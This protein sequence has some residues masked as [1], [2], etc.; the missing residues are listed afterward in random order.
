MI[1]PAHPR[2]TTPG[3]AHHAGQRV[4]AW[5]DV[6][7]AEKDEAK[8]LGARWDPAAKR[9]HDPRPGRA[10]QPRPELARWVA[11]VAVPDLLPG[12]DR[13]FGSGLFVDLI[14]E[15]CW[16]T[17]VRSCVSQQD[18][19]R[20]RRMITQRAGQ[21]CGATEDKTEQRWLEAHERWAY[22]EH[23]GVQA[24]RRLICLCS[25]C[26]LSTHMGYANVTGR[27]GQ[28]LAHLREVTGMTQSEASDHL[29]AA[30]DLWEQRSRRTWVLDLSLL[31]D[32]GVAL[33][34]PEDPTERR[35]AAA[36]TLA[37]QTEQDGAVPRLRDEAEPPVRPTADAQAGVNP[38]W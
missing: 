33:A 38:D 10:G 1:E 13:T 27:A 8:R 20:L 24:L 28:A 31:T 32:A 12:E 14:P 2:P 29:D 6:P 3:Q 36:R 18:W 7:F 30:G 4:R 19:E 22:D 34:R 15:S 9:W 16:F 37:Q 5:L 21:V 25:S 35:A 26:H 17:N 11:R 23:T